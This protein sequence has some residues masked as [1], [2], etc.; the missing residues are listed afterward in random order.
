[1]PKGEEEEEEE[2]EKKGSRPQLYTVPL[3]GSALLKFYISDLVYT[4]FIPVGIPYFRAR[5]EHVYF[6]NI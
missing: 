1:M 6:Y 4:L 3:R 5:M 2:E